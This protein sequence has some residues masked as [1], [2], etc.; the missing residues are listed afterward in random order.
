MGIT[1]I[2]IFPHSITSRVN[3]NGEISR[4]SKTG[5]WCTIIYFLAVIGVTIKFAIPV[6][7]EVGP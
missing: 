7:E 3:Y 4:K 6:F 1:A 5:G 2:D